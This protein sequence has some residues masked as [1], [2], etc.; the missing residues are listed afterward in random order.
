MAAGSV[1]Y[2]PDAVQLAD[3][4][5]LDL[6]RGVV[7]LTEVVFDAAWNDDQEQPGGR[8]PGPEPVRPAPAGAVTVSRGTSRSLAAVT[9]PVIMEVPAGARSDAREADLRRLLVRFHRPAAI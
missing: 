7:D 4:V 6:L 3:P 8:V 9:E 2:D 1:G 5:E